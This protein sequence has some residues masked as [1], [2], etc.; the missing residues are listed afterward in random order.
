M[1]PERRLDEALTQT[2]LARKDLGGS[3]LTP[4][5]RLSLKLAEMRLRTTYESLTGEAWV[6]PE[7]LD[8]PSEIL[9]EA[10][11][12]AAKEDGDADE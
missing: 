5:R 4:F 3:I 12:K 2:H 11:E 10:H 1:K 7:V 9:D 8:K 6:P